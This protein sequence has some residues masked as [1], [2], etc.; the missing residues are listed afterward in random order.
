MANR[1]E[2]ETAADG[3][4]YCNLPYTPAELEVLDNFISKLTPKPKEGDRD[5]RLTD[6][7]HYRPLPT[8][9]WTALPEP[10][11]GI[12]ATA[13]GIDATTVATEK[14]LNRV[15]ERIGDY[16]DTLLT[17]CRRELHLELHSDLS[18]YSVTFQKLREGHIPA[19]IIGGTGVPATNEDNHDPLTDPLDKFIDKL[20]LSHEQDE[21][22]EEDEDNDGEE[23]F[24]RKDASAF[25]NHP[26][27][28]WEAL[29]GDCITTIVQGDGAW[30]LAERMF[31]RRCEQRLGPGGELFYPVTIKARR[32]SHLSGDFFHVT[33]WINRCSD[34]TDS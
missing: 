7:I 23:T 25:E 30:V 11:V 34:S 18:M 26:P 5:S 29:P 15:V 24:E 19:C 17:E 12:T 16:S 20:V 8:A 32:A 33:M 21:D 22:E 4:G 31:R 28:V 27:L 13:E 10:D 9:T 14:F 3:G 6:R 1:A 2:V